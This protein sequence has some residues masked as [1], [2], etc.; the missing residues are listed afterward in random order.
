[1]RN[2]SMNEQKNNYKVIWVGVKDALEEVNAIEQGL[3]DE[4]EDASLGLIKQSLHLIKQ[5]VFEV[6][7]WED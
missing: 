5:A 2:L 4:L 6:T 1:M 7:G 3:P